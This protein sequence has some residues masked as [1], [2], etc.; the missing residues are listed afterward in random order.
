MCN[1]DDETNIHIY[2]KVFKNKN[3]KGGDPWICQRC[4]KIELNSMRKTKF[5]PNCE[6]TPMSLSEKN[7][8][9]KVITIGR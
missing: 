1:S 6:K 7:K 8:I 4:L 5:C 9:D 3:K 2:T